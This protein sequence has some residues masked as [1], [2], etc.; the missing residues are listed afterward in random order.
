MGQSPT[1]QAA[2]QQVHLQYSYILPLL[3]KRKKNRQYHVRHTINKANSHSR[4]TWQIS[5]SCG[6]QNPPG[7]MH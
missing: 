5:Q 4:G 2:P 3:R 7:G 1:E 6:A